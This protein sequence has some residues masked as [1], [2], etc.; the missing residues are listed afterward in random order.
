MTAKSITPR[1]EESVGDPVIGANSDDVG[2]GIL[3]TLARQLTPQARQEEGK[4]IVRSKN[5]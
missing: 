1:L 4:E 5:L 3:P 2:K